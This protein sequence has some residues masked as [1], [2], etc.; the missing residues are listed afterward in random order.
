MKFED[1][2]RRVPEEPAFS[3]FLLMNPAVSPGSLERQLSRWTR[4]GKILQL[5]RGL[6]AL[7]EPY[8]KVEPEPFLLANVLKPASY[9]SLQSALTYHGMIPEYV[10]T[11]TSVT[12]GRPETVETPLGRFSFR[13][14]KKSLFSGYTKISLFREQAA[15][16]ATPEKSL[17]DLVYLTPGADSSA[18]L[19]E[20]RLQNLDTLD[21]ERLRGMAEESESPK[22]IRAA[23]R[24][25][26]IAASEEHRTL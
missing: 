5:R 9:V 4:A 10:P 15:F 16:V 1:L 6:Y 13:H 20:L 26:H 22:L 23:E 2:L 19:Q 25:I 21:L 11:V 18:Y 17:L 8:Q 24:I 14:I 3:S 7:A 12:T